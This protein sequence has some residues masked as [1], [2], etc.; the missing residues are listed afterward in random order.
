MGGFDER[1]SWGTDMRF[2]LQLAIEE[3]I[4]YI[5]QKLVIVDRTRDR[6]RLTENRDMDSTAGK[7]LRN[8]RVLTYAEIYFRCWNQD[9]K[10]VKKIRHILGAYIS[11]VAISCCIEHRNYDAR[12]FA[13]DGM[14][15]GR[16]LRTYTKCV[17]VLFFPWLV[18]KFHQN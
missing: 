3:P 15:F 10:V 18:R 13:L 16:G 14:Y 8:M 5:S 4:A 11:S 12:R 2:M 1:F 9:K 17:A 7:A 6:E